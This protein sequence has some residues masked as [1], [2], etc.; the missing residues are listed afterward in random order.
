MTTLDPVGTL[1]AW[2]RKRGEPDSGIR[3]RGR[4][5]LHDEDGSPTI[6]VDAKVELHGTDADFVAKHF[7]GKGAR[8][9]ADALSPIPEQGVGKYD[10]VL[11]P[12]VA[13]MEAELH[14]N[15]GKGDRPGWLAMSREELLLEIYYHLAK[16]Q[17]AALKDDAGG[18]REFG[19]DVANMAMMLVDK[20]EALPLSALSP[21]S[22]PAAV[23]VTDEMVTDAS[24][25]LGNVLMLVSEDRAKEAHLWMEDAINVLHRLQALVDRNRVK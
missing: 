7:H 15:S 6:H 12:F 4:H 2:L 23:G 20:C 13:M 8:E 9:L 17:K 19:A 11:K 22:H 14:A 24:R 21:P 16:L 5:T 18:I 3:Y 10:E 1:I 25:A